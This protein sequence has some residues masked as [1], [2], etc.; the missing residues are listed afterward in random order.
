MDH[1]PFTPKIRALEEQLSPLVHRRWEDEKLRK[2]ATWNLRF[3]EEMQARLPLELR[4]MVYKHI[5]DFNT[6][7]ETYN[8]LVFLA[9]RRCQGF[10]EGKEEECQRLAS[11]S[12]PGTK[13]SCRSHRNTPFFMRPGYV[14]QET[15]REVVEAWYNAVVAWWPKTWNRVSLATVEYMTRTDAFFVGLNPSTILR[16]LSLEIYIDF[17]FMTYDR[18]GLSDQACIDSLL[19]IK[20]KADFKLSFTLKQKYISFHYWSLAFDM[21]RQVVDVFEKEGAIVQVT[22]VYLH[23]GLYPKLKWDMLPALR[24]GNND[25]KAGAKRDLEKDRRFR[26]RHR[27]YE[28]DTLTEDSDYDELDYRSDDDNRKRPY[29]GPHSDDGGESPGEKDYSADNMYRTYFEPRDFEPPPP[30]KI[31]RPAWEEHLLLNE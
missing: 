16:T 10:C 19:R 20:K 15:A 30:S 27:V 12:E 26:E 22:F 28:A 4:N 17:L 2:N 24:S 6:T 25:W 23:D 14:G 29:Y 8:G 31:R 9:Q 1:S 3:C 13:S 21:L 18:N 5:W 7:F 11:T